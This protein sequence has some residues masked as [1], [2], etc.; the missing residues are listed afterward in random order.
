MR[1]SSLVLSKLM[2]SQF[3]AIVRGEICIFGT[4]E[5]VSW[6]FSWLCSMMFQ[7]TMQHFAKVVSRFFSGKAKGYAA[8][9]ERTNV[10]ENYERSE[11]S[12]QHCSVAP[13]ITILV[14]DTY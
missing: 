8:F 13:Y 14:Q 6:N 12:P 4:M 11:S 3:K 1:Y 7:Q 10:L 5:Y 2:C 9:C